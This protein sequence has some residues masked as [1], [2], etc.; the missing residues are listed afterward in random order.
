MKYDNNNVFA[1]IIRGEIPCEKV[2]ENNIC[3]AF[4]D[5]APVA[6]VHVLVCPK[7]EFVS[8]DDFAEKAEADFMSKF[9]KTVKQIAN[10]LGLK[11]NGYRLVLNHGKNASQTV[12][13]FHVHIIGGKPLMGIIPGDTLTR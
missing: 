12:F 8:F 2:F 10:D 5:I 3:F 4:R 13:H 7:G 6:P 9:F 11:E 1:K